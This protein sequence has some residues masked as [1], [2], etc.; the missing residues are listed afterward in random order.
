MGEKSYETLNGIGIGVL[1]TLMLVTVLTDV[2]P[3][4]LRSVTWWSLGT[5]G[6]VLLAGALSVALGAGSLGPEVVSRRYWALSLALTGATWIAIAWSLSL[7]ALPLFAV[8]P[9]WKLLA[10]LLACTGWPLVGWA[11]RRADGKNRVDD[12]TAPVPDDSSER[13][14]YLR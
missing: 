7:L 5:I 9:E 11:R 1:G 6:A 14:G 4:E 12:G 13:S 2:A 8:A 10:G 3:S